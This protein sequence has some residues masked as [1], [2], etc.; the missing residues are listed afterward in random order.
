MVAQR[1]QR[2]D[3][4]AARRAGARLHQLHQDQGRKVG[5]VLGEIAQRRELEHQLREAR[6]Q[7]GV[8]FLLIDERA[9]VDR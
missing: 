3:R 1:I 5:H 4:Q 6:H 8:E 9:R 2:G 7:A